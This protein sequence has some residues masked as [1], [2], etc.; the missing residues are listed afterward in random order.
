MSHMK[1]ED[2]KQRVEQL[3]ALG[4]QTH[5]TRGS[6][7]PS[8]VDA[9]LYSDFRT[10][11]LSFILKL[12]D[13][14]HSYYIDFAHHVSA[15]TAEH[16]ERGLGILNGIRTELA[17]GWFQTTRGLISAEVFADFLEMA[18]HLLA[19]HYKDAAAVMI[20][21]VLEEH[22]RFLAQKNGL[23]TIRSDKMGN[24]MPKKADALNSELAKVS[25]Y[26]T[27]DQKNVT[28]NLDLRNKAAHG[29]Y[30]DYSQEQVVI[31]LQLVRDFV[32]RH[33]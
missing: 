30:N 25:V 31:M 17:G 9:K 26:N 14:T 20:G 1:L 19:E 11:T 12:F 3:I 24:S 22:L 13:N 33:S 27:L 28:A 18:E 4:N 23:A 32:A 6:G 7:R 15:A 10:S 16:V 21:S 5:S 29:H 8:W 2:L